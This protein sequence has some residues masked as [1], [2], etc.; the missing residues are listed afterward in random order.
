MFL[1][2]TEEEL[3][4]VFRVFDKDGSGTIRY[5]DIWL[6]LFG[7][8]RNLV[9]IKYMRTDWNTMIIILFT[10]N[11]SVP[12]WSFCRSSTATKLV[13]GDMTEWD[14]D[15]VIISSFLLRLCAWRNGEWEMR[16]SAKR[17][18]EI[19]LLINLFEIFWSCDLNL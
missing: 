9:V 10:L 2:D 14:R 4:E 7:T 3:I 19:T 5:I 8:F 15:R 11:T 17:Q 13:K 1:S 18:S 12:T 16:T 6:I